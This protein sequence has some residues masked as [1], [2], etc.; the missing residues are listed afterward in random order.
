MHNGLCQCSMRRACMLLFL[1][2]AVNSA[3]FRILHSYMLLL[4][5][6]V[7]ASF[8]P[9]PPFL[10]FLLYCE[11]P[12]LGEGCHSWN[13]SWHC[14]EQSPV[15]TY[16]T[17]MGME[18]PLLTA[19]QG[20]SSTLNLVLT[21]YKIDYSQWKLREQLLLEVRTIPQAKRMLRMLPLILSLCTLSS[22]RPFVHV[23][24]LSDE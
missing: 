1:V 16:D 4:E 22:W 8:S 17:G 10:S 11:H 13:E 5:H 14:V 3:R 9:P 15:Q 7:F 24:L 21:A 2:Q 23:C 12:S 18:Q 19:T 6:L 20:H